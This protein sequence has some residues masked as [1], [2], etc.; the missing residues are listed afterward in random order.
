[1][2]RDFKLAGIVLRQESELGQ[3]A[4]QEQRQ[5]AR[6]RAANDDPAV[7]QAPAQHRD[8][9][10]RQPAQQNAAMGL[11]RANLFIVGMPEETRGEHRR[12]RE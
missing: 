5:H 2:Q 10:T 3:L 7:A 12:E 6:S 9:M 1:M 8:I 4:E 11:L